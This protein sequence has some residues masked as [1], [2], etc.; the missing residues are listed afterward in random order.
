MID[1]ESCDIEEKEAIILW[2]KI[3]SSFSHMTPTGKRFFRNVNVS[4][5]GNDVEAHVTHTLHRTIFHDQYRGRRI[6]Q[7]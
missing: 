3:L 6:C 5:F 4:H 1:R 7:E 2:F